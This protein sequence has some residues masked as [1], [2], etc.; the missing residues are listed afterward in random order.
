MATYFL[1]S[2]AVVKC[3][4]TETGSEW[5]KSLVDP[6]ANHLVTLSRLSTVEVPAGLARRKREAS[7]SDNAFQD[8]LTAF[9][10][11]ALELYR[12]IEVDGSVCT[13]AQDLIIRHPLRAYDAMQ[14]ASALIANRVL[15]EANLAALIFLSADAR[16][17]PVA[18]AE[19]LGVDNPNLHP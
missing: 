14:L 9:R 8:A 4:V 1:D 13:L 12:L 11:D 5:M 17:L 7:I 18:Q 19:G 3:Y 6:A 10:R 2:S 15:L 16:L